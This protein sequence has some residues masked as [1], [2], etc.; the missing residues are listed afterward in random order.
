MTSADAIVEAKEVGKTYE[1][2]VEALTGVNLALPRGR[3]ST[4]LGP[5]GCG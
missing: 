2:G 1:G 3:L 5:S 4:L